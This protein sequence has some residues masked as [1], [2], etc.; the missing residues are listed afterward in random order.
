MEHVYDIFEIL[1]DGNPLW[2]AAAKGHEEATGQMHEL[3]SN[4][5][6]EVRVMH[7]GTK[8]TIASA[9]LGKDRN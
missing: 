2:R 9:N 4:T 5:A 3:A 6:N 1:P 8:A 7:L